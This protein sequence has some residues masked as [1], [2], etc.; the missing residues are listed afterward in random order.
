MATIRLFVAKQVSSMLFFYD[1]FPIT[2]LGVASR[3]RLVQTFCF[4]IMIEA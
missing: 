1:F 4:N 2:F 3:L